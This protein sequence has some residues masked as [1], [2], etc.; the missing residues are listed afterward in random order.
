[1][2]YSPT[3]RTFI[4]GADPGKRVLF[5]NQEENLRVSAQEVHITEDPTTKKQ[6][7]KGIGNVQLSFTTEEEA[8][9]KKWFKL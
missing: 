4:L 6:T 5:L 9:L 3:T 7:V 1:V 8:L 2:T